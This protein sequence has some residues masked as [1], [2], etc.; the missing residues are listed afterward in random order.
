MGCKSSY[1]VLYQTNDL[2]TFSITEEFLAPFLMAHLN[3]SLTSDTQCILF[4]LLPWHGA[5][6]T[7]TAVWFPGIHTFPEEVIFL[8]F[9]KFVITSVQCVR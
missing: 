4:L 2:E 7:R 9:F 1:V 5:A 6:H 8:L 3:P